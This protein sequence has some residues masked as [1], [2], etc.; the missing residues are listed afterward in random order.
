MPNP[1]I[2]I[3]MGAPLIYYDTYAHTYTF[4]QTPH[5]NWDGCTLRIMM[6]RFPIDEVAAVHW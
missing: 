1:L 4:A 6:G 2:I 3:G 5:Y